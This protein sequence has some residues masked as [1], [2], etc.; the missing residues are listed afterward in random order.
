MCSI[1]VSVYLLLHTY[2][3][4]IYSQLNDVILRT[5]HTRYIYIQRYTLDCILIALQLLQNKM[6]HI[7]S[8]YCNYFRKIRKLLVKLM[9]TQINYTDFINTCYTQTMVIKLRLFTTN[10]KRKIESIQNIKST[11][12]ASKKLYI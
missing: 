3:L 12:F 8:N 4:D 11:F 5:T 6:Q 7:H 10:I 1:V 2:S 9:A